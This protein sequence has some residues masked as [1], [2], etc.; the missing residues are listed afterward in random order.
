MWIK[1]KYL[2]NRIIAV[3]PQSSNRSLTAKQLCKSKKNTCILLKSHLVI[4][5]SPVNQMSYENVSQEHVTPVCRLPFSLVRFQ[6]QG[7]SQQTWLQLLRHLAKSSYNNNIILL[8]SASLMVLIEWG[9]C[10]MIN[11][12]IHPLIL[13]YYFYL[14]FICYFHPWKG[15]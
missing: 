2:L 13:S 8:P 1:I 9:I 14:L 10:L 3:H 4:N 7:W 15:R 5:I 12:L 11:P 6:K